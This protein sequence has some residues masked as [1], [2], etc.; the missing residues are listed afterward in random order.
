MVNAEKANLG[1]KKE[2]ECAAAFPPK[3]LLIKVLKRNEAFRAA[4]EGGQSSAQSV[5]E[6]LNAFIRQLAPSSLMLTSSAGEKEVVVTVREMMETVEY[7]GVLE[8]AF[9]PLNPASEVLFPAS[10]L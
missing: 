1:L 7:S 6:R 9:H 8:A 10:L 3:R 5:A 4:A 2:F